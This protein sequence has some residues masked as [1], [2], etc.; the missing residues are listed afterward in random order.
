MMTK[1]LLLKSNKMKPSVYS[2][3]NKNRKKLSK[4]QNHKSAITQR[5]K[6]IGRF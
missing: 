2:E 6:E 1:K 5:K 4:L 3:Y